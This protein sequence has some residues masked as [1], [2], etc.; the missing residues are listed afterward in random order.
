M[1]S[2]GKYDCLA[3][4]I[5]SIYDD[6]LSFEQTA[7][8][9]KERYPEQTKKTSVH[10]LGITLSRMHK[11]LGHQTLRSEIT[12]PHKVPFGQVKHYW[13]K[14]K[15]VSAFVKV[16][17]ED[18]INLE[19][20]IESI[21]DKF[22][23]GTK[24]YKIFKHDSE[25]ALI[26][27]ITDEHIGMNPN[28][29]GRGLFQYEY[30]AEIYSEKLEEYFN[31]LV[32]Q[33]EIFGTF[34]V[35]YLDNLG[36]RQDG[37][38]GYT[39]RGGHELDQNMT[40]EEVFELCVDSKLQFVENCVNAGIAEKIVLVDVANDNHSGFF[41]LM[42]NI[43]VSKIINKVYSTNLIKTRILRRFMEVVKYGNHT[44]IKTH[45][46]D[47]KYMKRGLPFELNDKTIRFINEFIEHYDLSG[48]IH[49]DKGDLHQ[50]GYKRYKLFD[51]NN[52]M[53]FA[54]PSNWVGHNIGDAYSGYTLRVVDKH[55]NEIITTDRFLDYK[56]IL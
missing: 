18:E 24:P 27:T 38:N 23:S 11:R 31:S 56:K 54:P 2:G 42:V 52:F 26:G 49:V 13:D 36:D 10:A 14:T 29:D 47:E 12:T 7:R 33:R 25:R 32:Q 39:T 37:L 35:L 1:A 8:I 6:C 17:P 44:F 34:E 21:V 46:K 19:E 20:R 48:F 43:A 22:V 3:D 9:I 41:G 55:V 40:N 50:K 4:E 45:G 16:N 53:S 51:Y 15:N 28:P 30:N 5:F